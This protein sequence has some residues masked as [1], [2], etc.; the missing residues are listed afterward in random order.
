[1]LTTEI[2][3]A[4]NI[5]HR[6]LSHKLIAKLESYG[7]LELKS[8]TKSKF[9]TS[10][11]LHSDTCIDIASHVQE[12][13]ITKPVMLMSGFLLSARATRKS[14][15]GWSTCVNSVGGQHLVIVG[16]DASHC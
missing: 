11:T 16:L 7:A 14:R 13:M 1:M 5:F 15:L 6:L 2:F 3:Y 10:T 12:H 8:G 9:D 4:L